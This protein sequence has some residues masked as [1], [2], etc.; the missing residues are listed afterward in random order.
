MYNIIKK[1]K[2][3]L[4]SSNKGAVKSLSQEILNEI[5][6]E[7]KIFSFKNYVSIEMEYNKTHDELL[8]LSSNYDIS[9]ALSEKINSLRLKEK[10]LEHLLKNR[11]E[12]NKLS[13]EIFSLILDLELIFIFDFDIKSSYF[14]QT[15]QLIKCNIE[16]LEELCIQLSYVMEDE[17][18][19]FEMLVELNK[20]Q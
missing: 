4:T 6:E 13:R 11:K 1:T 2:K 19:D 17:I 16:V 9:S 5:R 12:Q 10:R 7:K 18:K 3:M 20:I 14:K 8:E 15:K